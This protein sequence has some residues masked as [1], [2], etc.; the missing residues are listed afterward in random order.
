MGR[1]ILGACAALW[2][3]AVVVAL[4]A[5]PAGP[6]APAQVCRPEDTPPTVTRDAKGVA[7]NVPARDQAPEH[8]P[9]GWC[10][11]TAIQEAM[12]FHGAWF[13]QKHI[14]AAG[15]PVHPDLY[16]NEIPAALANLGAAFEVCRQES[17]DLPA[18]L[19]W[20]SR[21]I[22]QGCPV[23]VGV[24]INPTQHENWGLD[25]FVTAVA[26]TE[27][28]FVF[29]TTGGTRSTRTVQQLS[30]TEKG[31]GLKSRLNACYGISLRGQAGLG[32]DF[33]PV[34]LFVLKEDAGRMT[35]V[36][37]CEGLKAGGAY[38]VQRLSSCGQTDTGPRWVFTAPAETYAFY[39]T[40]A[41]DAPAIY[42][43]R[44]TAP[45]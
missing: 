8:P 12:L 23:L 34:R 5:A 2:V 22:G 15:R 38:A 27:D 40:V 21:Q 10:G 44:R 45:P 6:T 39:D 4:A 13:P 35:V 17:R 16:A 33:S 43:C 11:E 41:K 1:R 29:N 18:F 42:R 32:A 24:K 36:V 30:S 31:Y 3:I 26:C 37:K 19:R 9:E 20:L 7:L 25:H 28:A 14:N